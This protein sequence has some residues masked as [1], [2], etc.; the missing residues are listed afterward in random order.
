MVDNIFI[1]PTD[2]V[3]GLGCKVS[4]KHA[5]KEIYKIKQRPIEKKIIIVVSNLQQL[6][7]II[8][9]QLT[10]VEL[11]YIS[12][13][14]PGAITFIFRDN[15]GQKVAV[16]MPKHDK[17]IKFVELNGPIF[18]TSLNLSGQQ[19]IVR[20]D[21]IP[22]IFQHIQIIINEN[23]GNKP[24]STIFDL[25]TKKILRQGEVIIYQEEVFNENKE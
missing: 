20:L 11:G 2:T 15:S 1:L 16:R 8:H 4:N 9:R 21:Q 3:F 18:L 25:E 12:K 6:N 19:E 13:Y 22:K 14:W 5:L 7:E 23:S 24:A 10:K 17:L